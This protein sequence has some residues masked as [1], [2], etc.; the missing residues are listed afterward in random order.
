MDV[1]KAR[2]DPLAI[3]VDA[4]RSFIGGERRLAD[5]R[6]PSVANAKAEHPPGAPGAVE[7][8]ASIDG[9]VEAGH[10]AS[11]VPAWGRCRL[12]S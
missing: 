4:L 8:E 11:L 2:H 1:E 10:R 12:G 5:L 7:E 9:D 3:G 6:D